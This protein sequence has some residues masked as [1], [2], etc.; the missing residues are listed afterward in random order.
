MVAVLTRDLSKHW[1][2]GCWYEPAVA[3]LTTVRLLHN[4]QASLGVHLCIPATA[5]VAVFH[6]ISKLAQS[7]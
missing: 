4:T 2:A 6:S 1:I 7:H 3:A 5:C